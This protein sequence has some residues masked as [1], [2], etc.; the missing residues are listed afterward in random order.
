MAQSGGKEE[1]DARIYA[2]RCEGLTLAAIGRE[3]GLCAETVR[4]TIRQMERKAKWRET[5]WNA[6]WRS[7][8]RARMTP[9]R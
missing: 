2:R 8:T 1:R 5:G 7:Q 9:V 3:F 6:Q 4:L